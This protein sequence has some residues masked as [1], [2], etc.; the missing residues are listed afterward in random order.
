MKKVKSPSMALAMWHWVSL[1]RREG[2]CPPP[3]MEHPQEMAAQLGST[4]TKLRGLLGDYLG[5]KERS[6]SH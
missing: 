3:D 2:F 4:V 5:F 6:K 1:G